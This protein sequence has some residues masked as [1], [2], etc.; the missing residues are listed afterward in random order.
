MIFLDR[1]EVIKSQP[2]KFGGQAKVYFCVDK[3][4]GNKVAVK[5]TSLVSS[6]FART[7]EREVKSLR[8]L[9]H[10]GIIEILDWRNLGDEGIVVMPFMENNLSEY[11][12]SQS[13][14]KRIHRMQN[15][16]LPL[17]SA[18]SYAHENKVFHRDIKPT[19]ILV[20][21]NGSP[22]L[23][24]FGSA[25]V[26]G[27]NET[28]YTVV[29][30]QSKGYTPD[31]PGTPAQHD[32][33]SFAFMAIEIVTGKSAKTRGDA[34]ELLENN[35]GQT[36]F[37]SDE[38]K[39][40]L[41][42]CLELDPT[43]R[44]SSAME[45]YA[46][47]IER[48]NKRRFKENIEKYFCWIKIDDRVQQSLKSLGTGFPS[49]SLA[50]EKQL[51]GSI[52]AYPSKKKDDGGIRLNEFWLITERMKLLLK[53]NAQKT[54]WNVFEG[55][56]LD[57]D[58][59]EFQRA[60]SLDL[61][62]LGI[63]WGV[64][65]VDPSPKKSSEGYRFVTSEYS[66][67][68]TN[69]A[70]IDRGTNKAFQEIENLSS[71][72]SKILNAREEVATVNFKPLRYKD[73][74]VE[75]L[76]IFL[77]LEDV[78]NADN[79]ED[80]GD[81]DLEGT[82]WKIT[83]KQPEI[84]EVVMHLGNEMELLLGREPRGRV[85][86]VGNLVPEIEVGLASQLRRQRDAIN[87]LVSRSSVQPKLGDM[88]AN[89]NSIE[90]DIPITVVSWHDSEL[91]DSKKE[92]VSMA[93]GTK[94]FLL[95]KGP[96]GTGK[97]S[98]IAEYVFQELNRDS[99]LQ[100]LLV[101]QTHVALDNALDRLTKSGIT[102]CVRLGSADDK[103]ISDQSK[104]LL[105]DVQMRQWMEQMRRDSNGFIEKEAVK[106]GIGVQEARA[107]LTLV[108][109]NEVQ[110]TLKRLIE[111]SEDDNTN[112]E[113]YQ[114]SVTQI[115]LSSSELIVKKKQEEERLFDLLTRQLDGK[116]TI[117]R[118]RAG[119]DLRHI[120]GA[121]LGA[122][123]VS[124]EFMQIV[125]TQA[126]WLDR[127]GSSSQLTPVFLKTRRLLA[128]TC[129]GFM[130]LP[131]VRD[132]EFDICI[133]D[134]ASKAT[135]PQGLVSMVKAAKWIVVG[136]SKQLSPSELELRS[137]DAAE[138]LSK[139]ELT[140][141][142]T[143]ESV[144]SFLEDSLPLSKQIMLNTQYRMRNEIGQMISTL[145][146][147]NEISSKG[148]EIEASQVPYISAV[149]W[150][151]TSNLPNTERRE[152]RDKLSFSN[153]T[154]IKIIQK[155]LDVLARKIERGY[156]K[157]DLLPLK[158]GEKLKILVI[159]PYSA[160]ITQAKTIIGGDRHYPFTVEF[161]SVDAVQGRE[162]D[163]VFFSCVRSNDRQEVG[164]MGPKN[165]RRINVALSRARFK[166]HIVGDAHFW[167]N[168]RSDLRDVVQY[169]AD[170]ESSNFLKRDIADD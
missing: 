140:T 155:E 15:L 159:A 95:V 112:D 16:I 143:E 76:R 111:E 1:Y 105:V 72:W 40:I 39:L 130:S 63:K 166:L 153:R 60:S 162:A 56:L 67:W 73:A 106:A 126:K 120:Q 9:S 79:V 108:E 97:T 43:F 164:F 48:E 11:L 136:D 42:K 100:I 84:A 68:V 104:K 19:N 90:P 23:S 149:E 20:D 158:L 22:V 115:S 124:K 30:W 54:G 58:D 25:K 59:L 91:D 3:I 75:G 61:S 53:Q 12:D 5:I 88:L 81:I 51:E 129:I 122:Q 24:D 29:A 44:F 160:Q 47:F 35:I 89:L 99:N 80:V 127:V 168:T 31:I 55:F 170:S 156:I 125:D 138:I 62:K 167:S 18:L 70:P 52:F 45:M 165:W 69:G 169:I 28:D 132:L 163:I 6:L 144:F 150:S 78:S 151:D 133:I 93:L 8:R 87:A 7:F 38:T 134:E 131:E 107:L 109:L 110:Q 36:V 86:Q 96:P 114:E 2:I 32:V 74:K 33:Y 102:N 101:S 154:E 17:A 119:L 146:Y 50:L 145:F 14:L 66:E 152:Y 137:P 83:F 34:L 141:E 148:P 57:S 21:S 142:D 161:N 49:L 65:K 4:S 26:Y 147:A 98:F 71:R 157:P 128:G 139:Y 64:Y 117:P 46:K 94:D 116:L 10:D 77:T 103:R 113:T 82:F 37:F 41:R 92:A 123:E 118:E 13:N 85:Q 121:L 135:I 27:P